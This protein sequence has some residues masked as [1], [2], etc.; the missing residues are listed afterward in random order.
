MATGTIIL[1]VTAPQLTGSFVTAPARV[2]GGANCRCLLFSASV[3]E[4]AVWQFRMPSDY[5]S[6]LTAKLIYSMAS[7]T[8]NKVDWEVEVMA[9][10]DDEADPDTASFDTL[11]EIS[12]GTTVP[13][14]AGKV[15]MLDIAL[16]NADSVSAGDLV[17]IRLNRDHDDA[18]DTATGDAELRALALEYTTT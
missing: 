4:S 14:T 1:P 6:G 7:A 16:A 2:S 5:A 9:L 17:Q 8:T 12:G 15:D 10:S 3:T 18:D 13:G 11:N